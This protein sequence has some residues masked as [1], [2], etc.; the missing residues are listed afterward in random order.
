[1]HAGH[2]ISVLGDLVKNST[3]T[4]RA[5]GLRTCAQPFIEFIAVDHAH[6]AIFYG[7]VHLLVLGRDHARTACLGHQQ[8][9]RDVKVLDQARGDGTAARLGSAL[10]VQQQ[11]CAALQCQ[12]VGSGGASGTAADN[13]D[14]IFLGL[15][16]AA[17]CEG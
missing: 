3:H 11:N 12:V 10:A 1:M 14:V 17:P 4:L 2:S 7:D 13:D 9:V 15:H 16:G 8:V 6:K 5:M